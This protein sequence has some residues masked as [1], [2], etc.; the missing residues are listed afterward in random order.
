MRLA[1]GPPTLPQLSVD[2]FAAG[3][4]ILSVLCPSEQGLWIIYSWCLSLGNKRRKQM[5]QKIIRSLS[6]DS[7]CET[8]LADGR[9]ERR[10]SEMGWNGL[11]RVVALRFALRISYFWMESYPNINIRYLLIYWF[12]HL[13]IHYFLRVEPTERQQCWEAWGF[14]DLHG[15][16]KSSVLIRWLF[17]LSVLPQTIKHFQKALPSISHVQMACFSS[18]HRE[19]RGWEERSF[20]SSLLG[21]G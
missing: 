4:W 16:C 12:T 6:S 18:C 8:A 5:S 3:I 11:S 19:R 7:L 2:A 10:D 15:L 17:S 1:M 20:Q 13:F 21:C 14:L 9:V